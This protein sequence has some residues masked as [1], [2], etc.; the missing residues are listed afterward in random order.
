MSFLAPVWLAA[1]AAA[2]L[3]V[4][5]LHFITT[6]R[7][8][9]SR[10]PTARFVPQ[11]DERA[12]SRARRPADLLLL[13]LRC[14]ALM[15]L[16]AA[17]AGPVTAT[18]SAPL[19]RVVAVDRSRAAGPDARD[20]ALAVV[21][22]G[23]AV[24]LFD[25]GATI[26][27][28]AAAESLRALAVGHT[29]GSLSAALV[30]ARRAAGELS[31]TAD[32]VELVIVSPL[33]ADELDAASASMFARWPGRARLVRTVPARR[34]A[35]ALS[36]TG[37]DPDDPLAPTIAAIAAIA[38][39]APRDGTVNAVRI[40]RGEV[41]MADSAGARGGTAVVVW[42]RI[43]TGKASAQGLW[44][45]VATVVAP[46]TRLAIPAGGRVVARW[47]DGAPAA[48]ETALGAGCIRAVG[49][50]VPVAGDVTLQPDFTA[51]ARALVAPCYAANIGA[52]VADSVAKRYARAGPAAPAA[53]LRTADERSPLV[54]WLL[55]AAAL[56]LAAELVVRGR[57]TGGAA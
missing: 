51:V 54:S 27:T 33:T 48:T 52:A 39:D 56:V 46:L 18:R 4:V 11:G 16:G 43:G 5:A 37:G 12:A 29:R 34:T 57:T 10:L 19:V 23:D 53:A 15:L 2:A 21:R 3:G 26:V 40:V 30:G 6:Q 7:P 24:V 25:S 32:S 41:S 47:A 36:I 38:A 28:T 55:V 49:V 50:G 14:A 13:L 9:A 17:F 31:R 8:P 1:A 42:P 22:A 20:S 35:P 45:G 44:A